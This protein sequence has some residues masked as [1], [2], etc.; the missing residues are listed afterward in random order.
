MMKMGRDRRGEMGIG[1]MILFIAMVLVASVAS[2]VLISTANNLREQAL[3]T[4]NDAIASVSTGYEVSYV[5]GD[6]SGNEITRLHV[7][8]KLAPGSHAIDVNGVVVSLTIS[9]ESGSVSADMACD[10]TNVVD[11]G[12]RVELIISGLSAGPGATVSLK[13]VPPTGFLTFIELTIPD[14]L[15]NGTMFLR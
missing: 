13:I 14:V 11:Q 15:T 10:P 3:Q 1:A 7:H 2:S 5:T 9:S 6:V 4:G 8:L 12:D